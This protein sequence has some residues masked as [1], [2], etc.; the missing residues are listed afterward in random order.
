[1]GRLA[2]IIALAAACGGSPKPVQTAPLPDDPKPA[3]EPS[4]TAAPAPPAPP[5]VA[6]PEPQPPAELK[7]AAL[8]T[9]VKLVSSGTGKKAV[10][11]YAVK[12]G[13]RQAV[14]LAMDFAGEQDAHREVLP[15]LVLI[16]DAEIKAVDQD[17]SADYA[18]TITRT[19][20]R[21]VASSPVPLDQFKAVV[22]R[23]VGLTISSK[24]G[25]TGVAGDVTLRIDKPAARAAEALELLRLTLPALPV[26]PKEALGVGARWQATTAGKLAERIDITQV[27]SYEVVAHQGPLWTIKGTTTVSGKD[28]EL[29]G[30]KISGITGSGTVEL[31]LVDGAAYPTYTA[32]IET[33]FKATGKDL[34]TAFAIKVGTAVKP[35]P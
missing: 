7:I 35:T 3:V 17:G 26:L 32:S 9:T 22:D 30:N 1:M 6:A 13:T 12:P 28:Q 16:G 29:E 24:R 2:L 25:P 8:A 15:T 14:E 4:A 10:V 33:Q 5:P 19:D 11:R 34:S 27:T 31:S 20:A 18:L 23:L 21:A